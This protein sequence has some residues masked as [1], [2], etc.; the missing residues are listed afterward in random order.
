MFDAD[1]LWSKWVTE[2]FRR[3]IAANAPMKVG[4]VTVRA[5]RSE[6]RGRASGLRWAQMLLTGQSGL[7]GGGTQ[8]LKKGR[9]RDPRRWGL[10][11]L[12]RHKDRRE[13]QPPTAEKEGSDL[14]A[15]FLGNAPD[16]DINTTEA[17]MIIFTR[18]NVDPS[19]FSTIDMRSIK[20]FNSRMKSA[21]RGYSKNSRMMHKNI[22]G[23]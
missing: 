2:A 23:A 22:T 3:R 9:G 12:W 10:R 15:C 11:R 19:D 14:H 17:G 18:S 6:P 1:R 5:L 8:D 20:I 7:A 13:G 16:T 21:K 4:V